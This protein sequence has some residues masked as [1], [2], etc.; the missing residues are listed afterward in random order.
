MNTQKILIM[1]FKILF[2]LTL[3]LSLFVFTSQAQNGCK[4]CRGSELTVV[5]NTTI[6]ND[7]D[8][9]FFTWE[10]CSGNA[11]IVSGQGQPTLYIQHN[12]KNCSII[13]VT[14][15]FRG[16]KVVSCIEVCP[17]N[18]IIAGDPC[19][20]ADCSNVNDDRLSL[21]QEGTPQDCETVFASIS[22]FC[23][24]PDCVDYVT[25]RA[26]G[27]VTYPAA[28]QEV[29]TPGLGT[30]WDLEPTGAYNHSVVL[31]AT[32]TLTN[33]KECTLANNIW[34][35]CAGGP[36]SGGGIGMIGNESD[37][38]NGTDLTA[39]PNPVRLGNT[40][41]VPFESIVGA[42][43]VRMMDING[44]VIQELSQDDNSFEVDASWFPGVYFI[45]VINNGT[46]QTTSVIVN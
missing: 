39:Y 14:R 26:Q 8:A 4:D 16:G 5:N 28:G 3:F 31:Y 10:V 30:S 11:T 34:L 44:R 38:A 24:D 2:S 35:D 36:G 45:Q 40:L 9:G 25:W 1:N 43:S 17:D 12:D 13:K 23:V 15:Y 7:I 20:D 33:G 21:D 6:A 27:P 18:I 32:I 41:T 22:S 46:M 37:T 29:I 19:K 42:E